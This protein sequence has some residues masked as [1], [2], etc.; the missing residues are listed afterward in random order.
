MKRQ[1]VILFAVFFLLSSCATKV[2]NG[3]WNYFQAMGKNGQIVIT[4]KSEKTKNYRVSV[5]FNEDFT[6]DGIVQLYGIPNHLIKKALKDNSKL[7]FICLGKGV[8]L[9]SNG[10]I[11]KAYS[12]LIENS[13]PYIN[14]SIAEKMKE[15]S[16][17]IYCSEPSKLYNYTDEFD[18]YDLNNFTSVLLVSDNNEIYDGTFKLI[19]DDKANSFISIAKSKAIANLKKS[20]KAVNISEIKD[21]FSVSGNTVFL[22]NL[23]LSD[24][25]DFDFNNLLNSVADIF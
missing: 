21:Y 14:D 5:Q 17:S 2:I 15:H 6:Y 12:D 7:K 18:D 10:N 19:S 13:F 3:N 8:V 4:A 22:K 9:F 25:S 24:Y 20:G 11:E 16:L 23:F 1:A